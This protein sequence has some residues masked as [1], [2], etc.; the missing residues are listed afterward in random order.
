MNIVV[1]FVNKLLYNTSRNHL[2]TM[3]KVSGNM[4]SNT[5]L[6]LSV[7]LHLVGVSVIGLS[8]IDTTAINPDAMQIDFVTNPS[9]KRVLTLTPKVKTI[10]KMVNTKPPNIHRPKISTVYPDIPEVKS[11]VQQVPVTLL[12]DP[13][14]GKISLNAIQDTVSGIKHPIYPIE[15]KECLYESSVILASHQTKRNS[16]ISSPESDQIQLTPISLNFPSN[17]EPTK[18]AAFIRKIEPVYPESARLTHKEGL[19]V[20]EATI[21]ID[22]KAQDIRIVE[23]IEINGLGCEEAAI[24]A[25]KASQFSPALHGNAAV[26]Q[27]LRIPYRSKLRS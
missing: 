25:L 21:G 1:Q 13:L 19:V 12:N 27:R 6:V 15:D 17:T 9:P 26:S 14:D 4:I 24:Q 5:S 7:C 18:D 22:G 3:T 16:G 2:K 8:S 23:V 20:L 10:S 11:E